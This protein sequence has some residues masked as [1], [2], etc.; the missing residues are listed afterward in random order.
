VTPS[1]TFS[2]QRLP[3]TLSALLRGE[4]LRARSVRS[5]GWTISGFGLKYSLR[6]ISTLFLTRLLTPDAFGLMSLATM[7]LTGL[8]LISDIGTT[9]SI[10]RSKRGNDPVFLQT[11]WTLQVI[12]GASITVGACLLAWPLSWLYNEPL[13]FPMVAALSITALFEG[14]SSVGIPIARRQMALGKLTFLEIFVHTATVLITIIIAWQFRSV[15]A[16]VAGALFGS[17]LHLVLSHLILPPF[18][19]ALRWDKETLSE[20]IIFGRWILLA[21]LLTF[22]GGEGLTAVQGTLVSLDILGMLAVAGTL[23]WALGDLIGRVLGNIAF[24]ALSEIIRDRPQDV[25]RSMRKIQLVLITGGLPC[26][27]LLSFISQDLIG[28]MYDDR[29]ATAG[30]FLSI[31]ALNGATAVLSMPYQS[32][33]LAAGESRLHAFIM[34]LAAS[35]KIAGVIVGF[36]FGGV[37]GML[38]SIGLANT[39]VLVAAAILARQRDMANLSLD[40]ISVAVLSAAYANILL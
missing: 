31:M 13:L 19:H 20:I 26:F 36:H 12:R 7:V 5:A 25:S 32:A 30:T 15:W 2:F 35:L 33:L 21:T 16:I 23:A 39:L 27:L 24:P 4:T 8:A 11:A 38:A 3:Q 28:L 14:L 10:I 22:L 6:L 37:V 9:P 29:Y 34:G 1:K 18:R 17:I 40:V